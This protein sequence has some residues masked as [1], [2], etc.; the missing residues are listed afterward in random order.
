MPSSSRLLSRRHALR[1]A[2]WGAAA[3]AAPW[4]RAS[5]PPANTADTAATWRALSRLGYGPT[6][7]LI[8]QVQ[9]AGGAQ[10]WALSAIDAAYEDQPVVFGP[11]SDPDQQGARAKVA[12]MIQRL[13]S[14]RQAAAK[15]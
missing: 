11:A 12:A 15:H 13:R 14:A 6:P 7:A 9:Q 5:N 3:V 4:A 1:L 10:A 8:A 2:A